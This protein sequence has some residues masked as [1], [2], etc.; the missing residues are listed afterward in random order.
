[1]YQQQKKEVPT[2][3]CFNLHGQERKYLIHYIKLGVRSN[4]AG[5]QRERGKL[6]PFP[7]FSPAHEQARLQGRK[8]PQI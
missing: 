8:Q 4:D 6:T 7:L 5:S 3:R 1:M 2:I